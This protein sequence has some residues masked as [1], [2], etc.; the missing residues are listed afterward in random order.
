MPIT[1]PFPNAAMRR[2]GFEDYCL[3]L[4]PFRALWQKHHF[5]CEQYHLQIQQEGLFLD[6]HQIHLQLVLRACI[7]FPI[8]L[9]ITGQSAPHAQAVC[10]LGQLL[11]I[12]PDMLHTLGARPHDGHVAFEYVKELR[13]LVEAYCPDDP[14]CFR[15]AMVAGRGG[16][17]SLFLRVHDHAAEFEDVKLPAIS[18][19]TALPIKDRAAVLKLDTHSRYEH[20]GREEHQHQQ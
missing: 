3:S 16:L 2:F 11:R 8:N 14:A 4:K 6:I 19:H 1:S 5:H 9:G 7:I 18:G 17:I 12:F 13:R 20:K 10:K 15:D